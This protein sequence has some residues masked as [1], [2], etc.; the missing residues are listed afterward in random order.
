LAP[1]A[2]LS[3]STGTQTGIKCGGT[4]RIITHG[5]WTAKFNIERSI[6]GGT[7]WKVIR[8]FSSVN[9]NNVTT[10]QTD[11]NGGD[12]YLVRINTYS[13]TS[14]TIQIDLTTDPFTQEGW[15]KVTG[16]T[17][18]T[19]VTVDV[20]REIGIASSA[21]T[22]WAEGSWSDYRGWPSSV[23]FAQDRLCW[24]GTDAEPQTTWMTETGNYYSFRRHSPLVDTD[25]ISV[26]LP[27]RQ[28][29]GINWLLPLL[30][31]VAGTSSAIWTISAADK[32]LTPSSV[33]QSSNDYSGAAKVLPVVVGNRAIYVQVGGSVVRDLGFEFAS[34]GFVSVNAS[35][36][37][38]HLFNN[39]K[40]TELAYQQNPN[41][42]VW[43]I[44]NDGQMV[45]MTYLREQEVLAWTHHDTDGKFESI[46]KLQ[47]TEFDEIWMSVKRGEIRFI[48]KMADR[49]VSTETKDQFFVDCGVTYD[50]TPIDIVTGLEHLEGKNVSILAD[51]NVIGSYD[52]PKIVV[53][54]Q[55]DLG[56]E[57]SMVHV[58]L[59]YLADLETLNVELPSQLGTTQGKKVKISKITCQVLNSAGA[60]IG[61]DFDNLHEIGG[62]FTRY[63]T[64]ALRLF[65]GDFQE[66]LAA[67]YEDGGRI[68]IRQSDPLPI[69]ILSLVPDVTV[70]GKSLVNALQ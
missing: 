31:L 68:C 63:Y 69:S 17:S 48:E 43:G 37:A 44:R 40:I 13:Y 52:N 34:D 19:V 16:Y 51:G 7:T 56:G 59:P 26:N 11:D 18:A 5:T 36:L 58:G 28:L 53:G 50:G 60:K 47:G 54:G 46:C 57:Y 66:N 10:F 12:P 29:N 15:V 38:T 24:G 30:D 45:S 64:T 67:G 2:Y 33:N 22:D 27:S 14:G 49:M 55:I 21:V 25:G 32:V 62:A 39:F 35:I 70:G 3:R 9:D 20:K 65:T 6:D 61:P 4:W 41:N 8:T 1:D 42:I 23:S